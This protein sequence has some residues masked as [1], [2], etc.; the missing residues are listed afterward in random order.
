[1]DSW[2]I[3]N[4]CNQTTISPSLLPKHKSNSKPDSTQ[5][6]PH[7]P[8]HIWYKTVV[9]ILGLKVAVAQYARPNIYTLHNSNSGK[10]HQI[11]QPT[12]VYKTT[13][14]KLSNT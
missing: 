11:I 14:P 5:H 7:T 13:T 12:N 8:N 4:Q 10:Q 3:C 1:M 2:I 9:T 6:K